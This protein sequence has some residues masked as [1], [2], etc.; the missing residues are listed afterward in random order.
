MRGHLAG[1]AL[2]RP[3]PHPFITTCA[4]H[5][6]DLAFAAQVQAGIRTAIEFPPQAYAVFQETYMYKFAVDVSQ[7]GKDIV[8]AWASESLP[9]A[10][11]LAGG[12]LPPIGYEPP[13]YAS[14]FSHVVRR[15]SAS[16]RRG[17]VTVAFVEGEWIVKMPGRLLF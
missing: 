15:L 9:C 13:V 10:C 12:L 2:D 11:M 4:L 5:H 7:S 1:L 6:R 8:P 14:R 16:L 17:G 3:N